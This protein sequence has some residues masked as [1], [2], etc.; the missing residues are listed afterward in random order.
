MEFSFFWMILSS[1][2]DCCLWSNLSITAFCHLSIKFLREEYQKKI[3]QNKLSLPQTAFPAISF[4]SLQVLI[5]WSYLPQS[6]TSFLT[7]NLKLDNDNEDDDDDDDD[8][9]KWVMIVKMVM[10][11]MIMCKGLNQLNHSAMKWVRKAHYLLFGYSLTS[12]F[13]VSSNLFLSVIYWEINFILGLKKKEM[14]ERRKKKTGHQNHP[15]YC[16]QCCYY[17]HQ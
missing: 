3:A 1:C 11:M 8:D 5:F 10:M 6:M 16:H 14:N 2:L 9:E 7:L 13:V 15:H 12:L 4:A 17:Y